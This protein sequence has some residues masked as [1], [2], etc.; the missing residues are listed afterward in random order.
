MPMPDETPSLRLRPA[1]ALIA[2]VLGLSSA[3]GPAARAAQ[4]ESPPEARA[5]AA[6]EGAPVVVAVDTSRSLTPDEL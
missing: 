1:V 6:A 3:L 2:L 4:V 5:P